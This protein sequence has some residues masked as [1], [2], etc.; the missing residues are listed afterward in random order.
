MGVG[1]RKFNLRGLDMINGRG[2][3][4]KVQVHMYIQIFLLLRI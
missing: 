1:P 3:R 4:K 2:K